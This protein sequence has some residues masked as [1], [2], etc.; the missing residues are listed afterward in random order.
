MPFVSADGSLQL[1]YNGELYGMGHVRDSLMAGGVRF[2]SRTDTEVLFRLLE[3][4]RE[5]PERALQ[6]LNGMYAFAL[7]D[8][9]AQRLFLARD[10]L[11]IKPLYYRQSAGSVDFAS[12]WRAVVRLGEDRPRLSRD[13][14]IDYLRWGSVHSP[15]TMAEGVNALMPGSWLKAEGDGSVKVHQYVLNAWDQHSVE[16]TRAA[17]SLAEVRETVTGAVRGQLL[18]DRPVS[19]FL[20]GG[21]DSAIL[22]QAA[23]EAGASPGLVTIAFPEMPALDEGGAAASL[24]RRLACRHH[25]VPITGHGFA[26][27]VESCLSAF[28]QPSVDAVNTWLV[29]RAA[30][31]AGYTVALSGLGADELFFGYGTEVKAIRA[32]RL[33][34]IASRSPALRHFVAATASRRNPGGRVVRALE[35]RPNLEG[36][37]AAVRG[38]FT[39]Y[40]LPDLL[41]ARRP[42]SAGSKFGLRGVQRQEM[43]RYLSDRLLRDTDFAS[44]AHSLE[45]RVPFLDES[46]IALAAA[47]DPA[48][49]VLSR[50]QVLRDAFALTV[51]THKKQGFEIPMAEWL[52]GPLR[53]FATEGL[54]AGNL[55]LGV[56]IPRV[57]RERLWSSFLAGRTHWSRPWAVIVLRRWLAMNGFESE[58]GLADLR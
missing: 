58:S 16:A 38:M 50:K 6:S 46:V 26:T 20:S 44:M 40:D 42:E 9:S 10:N 8:H 2:R 18:A 41:E 22:A 36:S 29:S 34:S 1:V 47:F 27:V 48:D 30:S 11:G 14:V 21:T 24:A 4:H 54:L 32:I 19:I 43:Q 35:A 3:R 5:R 15:R 45:V 13:S 49:L 39:V 57:F 23:S 53:G 17:P 7:L 52:K 56:A 51:P 37:Y 25:V 55:P 28:D 31:E 33:A 12:E